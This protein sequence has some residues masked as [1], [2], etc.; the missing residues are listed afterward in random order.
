[1]SDIDD[2]LR[3]ILVNTAKNWVEE[4]GR[5][6][7]LLQ[8]LDECIPAIKQAF[9]DA[10][11]HDTDLE[12]MVEYE[13]NGYSMS[14]KDAVQSYDLTDRNRMTGQEWYDRFEELMRVPHIKVRK[15]GL[16]RYLGVLELAK[17]AAGLDDGKTN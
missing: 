13:N 15:D 12:Q 5:P 8:E 1:M 2:K 6:K 11:Y 17:R 7:H 16:V 4:D 10:G 3:E 9:A 14:G